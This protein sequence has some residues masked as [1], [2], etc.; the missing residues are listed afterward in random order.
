[1]IK[2]T[3]E[4]PLASGAC[5]RGS[6]DTSQKQSHNLP[7]LQFH[8]FGARRAFSATRGKFLQ[9]FGACLDLQ[10]D[11]QRHVDKIADQKNRQK[12]TENKLPLTSDG[13]Y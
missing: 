7:V 12:N 4:V 1:M 2:E 11:R 13:E 9:P 5:A 8:R 10:R 6:T 3:A